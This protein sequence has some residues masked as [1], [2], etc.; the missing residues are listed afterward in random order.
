MKN[1][2]IEPLVEMLEIVE[3][4]PKKFSNSKIFGVLKG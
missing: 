1:R 4:T 3:V 2:S